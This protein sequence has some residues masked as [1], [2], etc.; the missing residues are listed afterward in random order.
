MSLRVL[1]ADDHLM[2]AA[3]LVALISGE[4]DL[5]VVGTARD[6]REA[7]RSAC[8]LEPDVVVMDLSMPRLSGIEAAR[9]IV[10]AQPEI[11]ILCLSMHRQR[12]YLQAAL[13]AGAAGYVLKDCPPETVNQAIRCVARGRICLCP[14][15]AAAAV[16]EY[17]ACLVGHKPTIDLGLTAREREV[18]QMVAEGL[19]SQEIAAELFLSERTVAAHRR[20]LAEKLGIHSVAGLTKY[21]IRH[22]LTTVERD[23]RDLGPSMA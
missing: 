2:F 12:Q 11:K 3:G 13:E 7:V 4:P 1:L 19:T 22:G 15:M 14:E 20:H 10:T 8:E 21:A 5:E 16:E 18:L 6:G 9:Q 17:R 23:R